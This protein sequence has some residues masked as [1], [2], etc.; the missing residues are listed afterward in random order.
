MREREPLFEREP[1]LEREA[2]GRGRREE[3]LLAMVRVLSECQQW[4]ASHG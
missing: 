2:D 1:A 3:D 4:S